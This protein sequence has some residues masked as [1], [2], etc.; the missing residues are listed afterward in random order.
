MPSQTE[1]RMGFRSAQVKSFAL[2]SY[3]SPG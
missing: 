1:Q 2:S 3:H